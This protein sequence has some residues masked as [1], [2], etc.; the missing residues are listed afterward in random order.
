MTH[1]GMRILGLATIAAI[2]VGGCAGMAAEQ[3]VIGQPAAPVAIRSMIDGWPNV[4][5]MAAEAMIQK[6]GQPHEATATMLVW[7]DNGPWKRTIVYREEIQ[8]NFPMPHKDVLEQFVNYDVPV[9]MFDDLARYDGSVIAERT[10][11][12]ISAR[13][14]KEVA[15]L[16]AINLAHE[17]VTGVRSVEDARRMYAEQ[18]KAVMNNQP[19]PYTERLMFTPPANVTNP[20]RAVM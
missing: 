14:D 7:H 13:C 6:Y 15:N 19:A 4:S 9:D 1:H 3:A 5:Q 12:E 18:I 10:K 20:D 8:H 17:I 16:L 2:S 11:G